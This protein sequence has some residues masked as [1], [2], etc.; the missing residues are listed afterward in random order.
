MSDYNSDNYRKQG[1]EDWVVA[2]TLDMS[3]A[4]KV[5]DQVE[6]LSTGSTAAAM[7]PSGVSII[8]SSGGKADSFTLAT[9]VGAVK[10]I[11]CTAASATGFVHVKL[12]TGITFDGTN[13]GYKFKKA[14]TAVII[15][16]A[17]TNRWYE[18]YRSVA[19]GTALTSTSST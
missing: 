13:T 17:T 4:T 14:N 8:K 3:G 12:G 7:L 9:N 10:M 6:V 18:V 16:A 11:L 19:D 1:G 15:A 5:L 2:G